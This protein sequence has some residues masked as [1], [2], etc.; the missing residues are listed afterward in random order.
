MFAP[1]KGSNVEK[2][3]P[4]PATMSDTDTF[5]NKKQLFPISKRQN[6][7]I[8]LNINKMNDQEHV[9]FGKTHVLRSLFVIGQFPE[10][11]N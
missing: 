1:P 8:K 4:N 10:H 6:R 7:V 5:Q 11:Q 3:T 2:Q 9:V